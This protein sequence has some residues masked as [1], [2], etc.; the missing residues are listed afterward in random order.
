MFKNAFNNDCYIY[1]YIYIKP[2]VA[3]LFEMVD[4]ITLKAS[5]RCTEKTNEYLS[6]SLYPGIRSKG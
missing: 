2:N 5:K 6:W 3:M 1:I 4:G